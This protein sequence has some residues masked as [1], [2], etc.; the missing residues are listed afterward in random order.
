MNRTLLLTFLRQRF[1]SPARLALLALVCVF[2][3][4]GA[5]ITGQM[6]LLGGIA[7]P[8]AL[9]LAAG[10]VGQDISS[11]TLQLLLVRPVTRP[12]YLLHRWLA[13]FIGAFGLCLFVFALG[14]F[15][16]VLRSMAPPALDVARL[17]LDAA[18]TT[19]GYAAVIVMLSTLAGG[20]GD[21][22]IYAGVFFVSQAIMG[23]AMFQR[24]QWLMR[25]SQ[26]IQGVLGPSIPW[27]W[28][29]SGATPPWFAIVAW[30]S[31]VTLALAVAIARLNRREL[32]YAAD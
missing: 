29:G 23:V 20:I 24:W 19:A 15:A 12:S 27:A 2:P 32:S 9:I 18:T 22:A 1:T 3:L 25:V 7:A 8:I 30:A 10:A 5:A 28:I 13:V 16:L 4:G 14:I 6:A 11:G 21:L 26:E 17:V 31:T